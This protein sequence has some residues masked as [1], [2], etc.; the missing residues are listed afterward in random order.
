MKLENIEKKRDHSGRAW[1]MVGKE[2]AIHFYA[3]CQWLSPVL[4][5]LPRRTHTKQQTKR[6]NKLKYCLKYELNIKM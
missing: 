6:R 3:A 1:M 4:R 2:Y 5:F